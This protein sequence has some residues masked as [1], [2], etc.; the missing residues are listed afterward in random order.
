MSAVGDPARIAPLLSELG[1]YWSRHPELSLGK[2]LLKISTDCGVGLFHLSDYV[3]DGY[4]AVG[5][6]I[7]RE[8]DFSKTCVYG[9]LIDEVD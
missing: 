8:K 9:S 4:L 6:D 3:L 5:N 2:L 1:E 7:A